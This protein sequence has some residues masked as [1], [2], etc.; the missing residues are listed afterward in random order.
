VDGAGENLILSKGVV[1]A[2]EDASLDTLIRQARRSGE[3][4]VASGPPRNKLQEPFVVEPRLLHRLAPGVVLVQ[5]ARVLGYP[6]PVCFI[7]D[8][9]R[10]KK[11][12]TVIELLPEGY[13]ARINRSQVVR[14]IFSGGDVQST[15][16]L[17]GKDLMP[18]PEDT[19]GL[20]DCAFIVAR[21]EPHFFSEHGFEQ[22][23]SLANRMLRRYP[24]DKDGMSF[25]PA[26]WTTNDGEEA[27]KRLHVCVPETLRLV[28]RK[29]CGLQERLEL[30]VVARPRAGAWS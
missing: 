7:L 11:W 3:N 24:L 18:T 15:I 6:Q 26:P 30:R 4:F 14:Q 16:W 2:H 1:A 21:L 12:R 20:Y 10:P 19:Q 23:E 22:A 9:V 13:A 27:M 17:R 29:L 28:F 8:A 5:S 25:P